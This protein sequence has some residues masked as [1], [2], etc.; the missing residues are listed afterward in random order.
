MPPNP[1]YIGDRVYIATYRKRFV[2]IDEDTNDMWAKEYFKDEP[3][4]RGFITA[5]EFVLTTEE[6]KPWK[7]IN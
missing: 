4:A 7:P 2:V 1:L 3:E 6:I 5:N